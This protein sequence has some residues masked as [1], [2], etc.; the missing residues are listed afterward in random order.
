MYD[1]HLLASSTSLEIKHQHPEVRF[2]PQQY[3]RAPSSHDLHLPFKLERNFSGS[4]ENPLQVFTFGFCSS[5]F[6]KT[7]WVFFISVLQAK[8]GHFSSSLQLRDHQLPSLS[9]TACR[10][11]T[12]LF[13]LQG[14]CKSSACKLAFFNYQRQQ[15]RGVS[16][17][18]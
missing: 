2:S 15:G 8:Y 14:C 7:V 6:S 12:I 9:C 1:L 5:T 10:F 18:Y 17:G 13:P 3:S 4:C 11:Y 16:D